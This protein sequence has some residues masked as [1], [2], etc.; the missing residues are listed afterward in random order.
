MG[1]AYVYIVTVDRDRERQR[2]MLILAITDPNMIYMGRG[3]FKNI[4][5]FYSTQRF[6]AEI[7]MSLIHN[8]CRIGDRAVCMYGSFSYSVEASL[9]GIWFRGFSDFFQLK[10]GGPC[11]KQYF[12]SSG[13][14]LST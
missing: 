5:I 10:Y 2:E 7:S 3:E 4:C 13:V 8:E 6:I 12:I 11:V 9:S 1:L 14:P